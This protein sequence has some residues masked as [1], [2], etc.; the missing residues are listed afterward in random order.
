MKSKLNL[1]NKSIFL[2]VL[3]FLF[4]TSYTNG[5]SG[6]YKENTEVGS[7]VGSLII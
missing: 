4:S 1:T 7:F 2:Y 5:Q 3:F 6:Q